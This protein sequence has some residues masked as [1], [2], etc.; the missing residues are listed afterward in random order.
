MRVITL[1]TFSCLVSFLAAASV[2]TVFLEGDVVLTP[3]PDGS[4]IS[5]G[6]WQAL[7]DQLTCVAS[8]AWSAAD[9]EIE[10]GTLPVGWYR[11]EFLDGAGGVKAYTTAAVLKP[12]AVPP[13]PDT[14][15]AVDVALSWVPEKDPEVW[16]QCVRLAKLAGVAMVRDRLRWRDIQQEEGAPLLQDTVYEQTADLQHANGLRVL[17]VFHD[18]PQWTWAHPE[19]RGRIP[20]D[21]RDTFQFCRKIAA[22]FDGR[23]QAWQPWNEGNAHNFGG[24]TVDELCSHQKAAFLGF[25][26]G[27]A[28][29]Q[30]CWAPM[31]GINSEPL[32]KGITENGTAAYFDVYCMH[33]YNWPH[34][35]PHL[36]QYALKAAA[37]KP[38]WVTECD[39][40]MRAEPDSPY[41][42]FSHE[43]EL[44][45]AE[46]ITQEIVSSLAAGTDRH[47]HFILPQYMEQQHSVQFGLLRDDQTPRMGY[48]ALAAAG[49]LLA[50][51]QYLGRLFDPDKPDVYIFAFRTQADGV[52]QDVLAAWTEC[53]QDWPERGKV[54]ASLSLPETL[55]PTAVW[56]FLGRAQTTE[57]PK[58]VTSKPVYIMLPEGA[59]DTVPL[60]KPAVRSAQEIEPPSP[61]VLQLRAPDVPI[62]AR[63]VNW[64]HETDRV[65]NP[66]NYELTINAY[67]FGDDTATGTIKVA[68]LPEGWQWEPITWEVALDPMERHEQPVR[69]HIPEPDAPTDKGAWI[70]LEGNFGANGK[71]CLA[72]RVMPEK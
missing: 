34:D 27:D 14:P 32:C 62:E 59:T 21:L 44:R 71:P 40:G 30:V 5:S 23:V 47:F 49:R 41:G 7:D 33:S 20:A 9:K 68:E 31:G 6:N 19:E 16:E 43:N 53:R 60:D 25:H 35:Y 50:G 61:V 64:A 51:A 24:H 4:V 56:D 39:R 65:M 10:I 22:H 37:G 46:H 70:K 1:F 57:V 67:C 28:D 54:T 29:I 52:T 48:V 69:L 13:P 3:K 38:F 36:R 11:V 17:Q 66:G 58:K 42:D 63:V 18:S 72:F 2:G 55:A 45:K 8:G 15:V 12:L 26:A